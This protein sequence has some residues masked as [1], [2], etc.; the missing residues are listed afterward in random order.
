MKIFV[1]TSILFL[2]TLN[3]FGQEKEK[4]RMPKRTDNFVRMEGIRVGL[5]LTRAYQ[6]LWTKGNRYGTELSADMEMLPNLFT[7][8]ET[9]WEKFKLSQDYVTYN[10]SGSYSRLGIDYNFL[11]AE[12]K[13]DMDI[14]YAGFRYGFGLAKQQVSNYRIDS[15][16]G[17]ETGRFG[18]QNY[19]SHWI[20]FLLG[21]KGEIF[22]NF[23]MGWTIRTKV[24]ITQKEYAMPPVY[25]TPG[26]GNNDANVNFDFTYSI[27]YKLPFNFKK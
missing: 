19:H 21:M 24:M 15:Y 2:L 8:V 14:L 18:S 23:F 4:K 11:T 9:G 27:Y 25:F 16:W 12:H 10:S 26:Y 3:S 17:E 22:N 5:D 7:V 6:D 1:Y 13:E 20:E